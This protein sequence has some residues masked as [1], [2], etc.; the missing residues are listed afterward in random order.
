MTYLLNGGDPYRD[1]PDGTF[2]GSD[3]AL[4][5]LDAITG[6]HLG[7]DTKGLSRVVG[8]DRVKYLSSSH[9]T[10][11]IAELARSF[12]NLER[13][14][15]YGIRGVPAGTGQLP[16]LKLLSV[17]AC[18]GLVDFEPFEQC[19]AVETF[20][21]SGCIHLKTLDR[22]DRMRNLTEFAITGS[23]T[24]TGTIPTLAPLSS[25]AELHYVALA[26]RIEDKDISPLRNL[27]M[28]RYLWLQN[29]FKHDQYEA[30]LASCP[31][32]EAIELHNGTFDRL[33]GF[34]KDEE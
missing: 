8:L 4:A 23:P 22:I 17:Y 9:W 10:P 25:C 29:R 28:L 2:I 33:K 31:M 27:S 3:L 32:L 21:I 20:W 30:I 19:V 13:L 24:K 7:K 6:L 15:L 16:R 1:V 12:P 14:E 18:S 11:A 5:N 34:R 26:T